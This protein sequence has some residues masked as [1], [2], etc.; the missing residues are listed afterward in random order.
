MGFGQAAVVNRDNHPR[1]DVAEVIDG[2]GQLQPRRTDRKQQDIDRPL[3]TPQ[4][5]AWMQDPAIDQ[6]GVVHRRRKIRMNDFMLDGAGLDLPSSN[7][8][9][10]R[11]VSLN[12]RCGHRKSRTPKFGARAGVSKDRQFGRIRS[13]APHPVQIE[14]VSV[15]V[16]DQD[17]VHGVDLIQSRTQIARI[18]QH[19]TTEAPFILD[20]DACVS[21][22]TQLHGVTSPRRYPKIPAERD[23]TIDIQDS[24]QAGL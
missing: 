22:A 16:G 6:V 19:S 14:V 8:E 17:R 5:V 18:D 7:L 12:D 3:R 24:H 10:G 9:S 1:I 2:V 11:F 23:N 20:Q 15:F 4:R 21:V 13:K